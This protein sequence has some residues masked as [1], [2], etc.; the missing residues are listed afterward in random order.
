[1]RPTFGAAAVVGAGLALVV[2]GC[3]GSSGFR[4]R[5]D[6]AAWSPDGT[7]IAFVSN[8]ANPNSDASQLYVVNGD[9]GSLRRLTGGGDAAY[10]RFAPDGR[11]IAYLDTFA[12]GRTELVVSDALGR[13]RPIVA[14]SALLDPTIPPAWSPD[15]GWIAFVEERNNIDVDAPMDLWL[16]SADGSRKLRVA[17]GIDQGTFSPLFAWSPNGRTLAFGCHNGGICVLVAPGGAVRTLV[18]GGGGDIGTTSVDWSPNGKQIAFLRATPGGD[19]ET[20]NQHGWVVGA[21]GRGQH[22]LPRFGEGSVDQL[23]WVPG[24]PALLAAAGDDSGHIYLLR[25][26]G[27]GK[28]DLRAPGW[29]YEPVPSPGGTMIAFDRVGSVPDNAAPQHAALYVASI[30]AGSVRQLTQR[31]AP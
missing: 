30:P 26:D 9:G 24:K 13:G 20:L 29:D 27:S 22:R 7:R 23:V 14:A 31:N 16:V 15:G 3:G 4:W 25:S 8:R 6:D 12:D 18:R 28:H 19:V 21:D 10:P 11:R 17:T 5:D 2:G 1:M